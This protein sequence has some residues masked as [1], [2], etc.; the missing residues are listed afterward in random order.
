MDV[1]PI[2]AGLVGLPVGSLLNRLI[3]REPGYVITDPG[4]LPDDADPALLDEL[5]E[6]PVLDTVPVF[7]LGR[8]GTW[9]RW[10][11]P[12]TEVVTAGLFALTAY[13]IGPMSEVVAVLFLVAM[14]VTLAAVDLRVYRIPDR[15]NFPSMAIGLGVL[16]IASLERSQPEL[17]AAA[18][19]GGFTY[20][21]MLF[22][23]HIAYPRG[24]GWGDVK[25]AWL[26]GF[27]IGWATWADGSL[28][29]QYLYV[30]RGV[31]LAFGVGSLL[32]A[33]FGGGYALARRSAKAVFPYGPSL[34]IG[35]LF[36]VL[37]A[38][39]LA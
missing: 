25:L 21:T 4:D 3:V 34:A 16:V 15:V 11:F 22:L 14:L 36:V 1:A 13:R 7:A 12:A 23:A 5:E 20:A 35:C 10:W 19:V 18:L 29:D 31:I 6:V 28:L 38:P 30:L 2:I 33:V 26:M 27:Y 17:I 32:G 24:M 9:W 8:P 37:W 39:E